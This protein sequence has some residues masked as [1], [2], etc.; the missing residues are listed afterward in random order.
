MK[1]L[2]KA[3]ER[4][5]TK[6]IRGLG[7]GEVRTVRH[8]NYYPCAVSNC[9]NLGTFRRVDKHTYVYLCKDHEDYFPRWQ[10]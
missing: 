2:L 6:L 8:A 10:N 4:R 1:E 5:I 9:S 3:V 7:E